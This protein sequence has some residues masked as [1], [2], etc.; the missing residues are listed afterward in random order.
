V[1]TTGIGMTVDDIRE[2]KKYSVC[3]W[4]STVVFAT[5]YRWRTNC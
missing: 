2:L 5:F 3:W 1:F 4:H